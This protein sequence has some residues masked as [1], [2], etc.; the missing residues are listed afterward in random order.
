MN[1]YTNPIIHADYSDPDVIRVGEDFYMVAS[2]FTYFPGVPLLHSR[3]LVHWE[4]INYCVRSLPFEKYRLPAHGSGTWAP[5]IRFH[6]GCFYVFIPLVDEGILV[7]RSTDP[8]AEFEL[9]LL[10]ESCGWIDPCPFWDDDGKTYMIFAYAQS[11]CG[12]KHRLSIVELDEDCRE[13]R[14]EPICIFDGS[15]IAP[16]AEGPKLYKHQG[17]YLVLF[18]AG[19]VE[20]GWQACIRA[21]HIYGPYEYRVVMHRG[22]SGINGPHQGGWVDAADGRQWFIH[23]QDLL[24]YGRVLHLQP[25][26]FVDGWPFIGVDADGDGIGEPVAEWPLPIEGQPEYALPHS[27]TFC[28]GRPGLQWQWQANPDTDF[29]LNEGHRGLCLRCL[30]R[31]DRE[32]LLWYAPNA[33]TQIPEG[34]CLSME[35]RLSLCKSR[36]GDF[37]GIGM[38]GH[39]YAYA[40]IYR[41]QDSWELR[42]YQGQVTGKTFEGEAEECLRYRIRLEKPCAVLKMMLE[43]DK[44]YHFLYAKDGRDFETIPLKFRLQR[45]TWTG[46]KLCLW[47]CA[48]ENKPSE[49][50]CRYD[51][52]QIS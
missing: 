4:L 18:P 16:T 1:I 47:A 29:Y 3:D 25:L 22:S 43:A 11:R 32:N 24:E 40:G 14:S 27:D 49:G 41:A 39:E 21:A 2:S 28:E 31:T 46:A 42:V 51:Y 34:S 52:V 8:R 20:Q 15:Q 36:E 13:L 33:L 44:Y 50:Y 9:N 38:L 5:S 23:F 37:G 45:A 6:K 26:C 30:A 12:I 10:C 17:Q 48:R 19:G 7:A 35:S